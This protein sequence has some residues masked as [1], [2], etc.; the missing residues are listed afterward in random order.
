MPQQSLPL[1]E[2]VNRLNDGMAGTLLEKTGLKS[3]IRKGYRTIAAATTPDVREF[4]INGTTVRLNQQSFVETRTLDAF[5]GELPVVE[6]L[7]EKIDSSDVYWDVGA[8]VGAHSCAVE[9]TNPGVQAL[10]FEPVP[11]TAEQISA[12]ASLNE[13][14]IDVCQVALSN[15]DGEITMDIETA[16]SASGQNSLSSTAD[17]DFTVETARADS[18]L[19]REF[20]PPT[21]MKIDVEGAEGLVI[22]GATTVLS[23]VRLVYCELHPDRM[24]G[25]GFTPDDIHQNLRDFGFEVYEIHQREDESF[26]RGEK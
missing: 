21:V 17:G 5:S 2:F 9:R 22:D 3:S 24:T 15:E 8:H 12:N 13:V 26:I 4:S 11:T 20:K 16:G 7:C 18:L 1:N 25:F 6:D 10:A 23:D 19:E 14:E